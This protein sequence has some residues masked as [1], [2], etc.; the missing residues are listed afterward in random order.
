MKRNVGLLASV[1]VSTAVLGSCADRGLA[2]EPP[3]SPGT[4]TWAVVTVA[5]VA[6]TAV[7]G[8]LI[9]LPAMR[10]GGSAIGSWVL[11]LQAG[12]VAVTSAIIV[13]AAVRNEQLLDQAPDAEQAASL[14]RL[15]ALDG[16]ESG[17]FTLIVLVTVIVGGLLIAALALAARFA[18]DTDRVERSLAAG[19]LGLEVIGS[20][21][22]G[23]L[24][25]LGFRH[26]GFVL[27]AL[28]LPILVIATVAVWPRRGVPVHSAG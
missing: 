6:A 1:V 23:V 14:L 3:S 9:V 5:A 28:A 15:S 4:A 16:R 11:A 21:T 18:A 2:S 12:G 13:G 8:A 22:C 26:L 10:P 19:L 27:P 7:L 17:F 25:A 20:L 24:V